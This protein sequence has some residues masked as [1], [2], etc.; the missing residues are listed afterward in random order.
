MVI[1]LRH[2]HTPWNAKQLAGKSGDVE[3][4]RGND[5]TV[6]LDDQG[7]MEVSQAAVEIC[8]YPVTEVRAAISY[9]RDA[10]T[11][12]IVSSAC[13]VGLKDMPALAPWD[14]GALTG[15]PLE[16]IWDLIALLIDVPAISPPGGKTVGSWLSAW[17]DTFQKVYAEYGQDDT[18]AVVL[19]VHGMEMRALP[20][21]TGTGPMEKYKEQSVKPGEFVVVH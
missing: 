9:K 13:H 6:D 11:G 8:A 7:R 18:R 16:M 3:S 2:G 1:C 19:I 15:M 5:K 17:I 4:L 21:V 14:P 10:S 12:Q 20:V